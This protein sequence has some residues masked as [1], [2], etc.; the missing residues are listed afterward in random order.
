V[1]GA[2]GESTHRVYLN[3]KGVS[4]PLEA[5]FLLPGYSFEFE[6]EKPF[7]KSKV[8]TTR[9]DSGENIINFEELTPD[10]FSTLLNPGE[11]WNL[12]PFSN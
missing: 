4:A 5:R 6:L 3:S 9:V 11:L 2:V 1:S 8:I 12:L 7:Y 10:I